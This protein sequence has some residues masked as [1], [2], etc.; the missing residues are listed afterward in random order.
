MIF[1]KALAAFVAV[2][3]GQDCYVVGLDQINCKVFVLIAE[4]NLT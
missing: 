1:V 4:I 3:V 2:V